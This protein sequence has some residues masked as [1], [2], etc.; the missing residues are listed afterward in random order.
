[1]SD[2]PSVAEPA[3]SKKWLRLLHTYVSLYALL[4]ILFF[5]LTGFIMNHP[6]WFG[7]GELR[8]ETRIAQTPVELCA[9]GDRLAIAEYLRANHGL[10]GLV[11]ACDLAT[12]RITVSFAR[13]GRRAEVVIDPAT[14]ETRIDLETKGMAAIL[15]AIHSGEHTGR[16]GRRLIDAAALF[17]ILTALTGIALWGTLAIRRETGLIWLLAS[18][19][20][21]L[22][23]GLKLA[24]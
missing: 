23:L 19:A 3:R 10:K 17:L 5:G 20:L 7:L 15:A 14:G 4:L 2:Q 24:L 12:N 21:A 9:G 18:L 1:M 8:T 16:F 11:Q 22:I 13:A 6:E